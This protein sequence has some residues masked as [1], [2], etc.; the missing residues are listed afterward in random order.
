VLSCS[1]AFHEFKNGHPVLHPLFLILLPRALLHDLEC[2]TPAF[3]LE[4]TVWGVGRASKQA[5]IFRYF[6]EVKPR[7][8]FDN[9]EEM[10][11]VLLFHQTLAKT[12]PQPAVNMVVLVKK[13]QLLSKQLEHTF[14][15]DFFGS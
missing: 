11:R 10:V 15:H 12:T 5:G 9:T 2:A 7:A 3:Q 6:I 13:T 8:F 4:K 1:R 14:H